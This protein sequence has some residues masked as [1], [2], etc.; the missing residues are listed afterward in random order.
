[1]D[2]QLWVL[3]LVL[4]ALQANRKTGVATPVTKSR[5]SGWRAGVPP[6]AL[7][8]LGEFGELAS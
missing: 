6:P 7:G 8:T 2:T 3:A 5:Q 1:M 4:L